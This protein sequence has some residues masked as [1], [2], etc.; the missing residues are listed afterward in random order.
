MAGIECL[1]FWPE[2]PSPS[3]PSSFQT[4][5]LETVTAFHLFPLVS[6][7]LLKWGDAADARG[8]DR[9]LGRLLI[10]GT[11]GTQS[12]TTVYNEL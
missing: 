11:P 12:H 2:A 9:G 10:M 3:T 4:N 7:A 1:C 8:P 5:C 6:A